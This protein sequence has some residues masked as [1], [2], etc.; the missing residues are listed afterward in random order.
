M[1]NN[2]YITGRFV[3]IARIKDEFFKEDLPDPES[4]IQV[5]QEVNNRADIFTFWQT[6]P[7]NKPRLPYY[8][9]WDNIATLPVT[10]YD[11]WFKKQANRGVR[12]STET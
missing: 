5:L 2:L 4:F 1:E 8:M 11:H 7:P 6:L 10:R 9:E 3:R 12:R